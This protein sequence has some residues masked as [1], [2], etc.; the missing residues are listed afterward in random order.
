MDAHAEPSAISVAETSRGLRWTL[1]QSDSREAE[2]EGSSMCYR[3]LF[4]GVHALPFLAPPDRLVKRQI[5]LEPRQ[6]ELLL[7]GNLL[8]C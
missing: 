5:V 3:L 1:L 7:P 4:E 6:R 2:F 8:H